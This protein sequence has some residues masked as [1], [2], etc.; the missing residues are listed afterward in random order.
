MATAPTA[1]PLSFKDVLKIHGLRRLWIGQLVS[2]FGDFLAIFAIFSIISFRM[3]GTP[4]QVSLVL[5]SYFLPFV[6]IAP[7]AGV[8]VD[9]WNVKRTMIASD[10]IRSVFCFLFLFVTN[11]WEIYALLFSLS[12]VSTFFVP[13]QQV[14]IRTIVP[15]EGLMSANGLMQ[16]IFFGMQIISPAIA[17]GLVSWL[18]PGSCFW[19]DTGS[20]F[21][22]AFMISGIAIHREVPP[23]LNN[24]SSVIHEINSGAK[25]IFTHATISFVVTAIAAGMFA[26]RAFGAL[27][28]VYVRDVLK[29]GIGLFGAL[30]TLIGI[31]MIVGTQLIHRFARNRSKAHMVVGGLMGVGVSIAIVGLIP[32]TAAAVVGMLG[33]GFCASFLIVPSQTL[34]QEETPPA[35][36]GRVGGSM[37][38]VMMTAQVVGLTVAGPVVQYIGIRN[39]Y[40]ASAV[41]LFLIAA[42]GHF[43]LRNHAAPG[44]Q[45]ANA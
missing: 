8:F 29:G 35:M 10:L 22:S 20:F 4:T 1:P 44:T 26:I 21:V 2:V 42:V 43:K 12:A 39:L 17:S 38:S 34:I 40:Y 6:F 36:L 30:G 13:A 9:R 14:T 31:G 23:A 37:M 15:R 16:Q 27:I 28:A 45:I 41:L 19:L 18:G 5:I 25:F 3:H 7:I 32:T 24:V 33:M 11:V